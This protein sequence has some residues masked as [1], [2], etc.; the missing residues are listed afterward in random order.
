M[1][2]KPEWLQVPYNDN[3]L[4]DHTS[5]LLDEL[6]LNTVCIEANCPNR[7]ECFA[8]KTATFMILGTNCTRN[9]TF[10]NVGSGKPMPVDEG[11]PERVAEA[12]LKLNLRYVVITSVTRDDLPDDGEEHF[13]NTVRAIRKAA[14]ETLIETLIPDLADIKNLTNE[15]PAVISHNIETVKSL[16]NRVRPEADY[17]WSLDVLKRIKELNPKI[18][19]KTGIMLGLGETHKEILET[20]EDIRDTGCEILTIGQYLAPSKKH[21]PVQSYI[22]PEKFDEYGK[23]AKERGF[24]HVASAPF[25]RSS[26]KAEN[27]GS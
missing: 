2:K 8:N 26:Y 9:C 11:E 12:V 23:I 21:Y 17:C 4:I 10:C 18:R 15:S 3:E 19:T 14:P 5:F 6:R 13:V 7:G 22:K 20:F 25:V 24:R 16:Y 1:L 27:M